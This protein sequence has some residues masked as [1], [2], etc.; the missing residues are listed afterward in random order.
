LQLLLNTF[1]RSKIPSRKSKKLKKLSKAQTVD[2]ADTDTDADAPADINNTNSNTYTIPAPSAMLIETT[3]STNIAQEELC[4]SDSDKEQ[5]CK[6]PAI[7][8][9]NILLINN[10][11]NKL[12]FQYILFG[13]V[14]NFT[15]R[16]YIFRKNYKTSGSTPGAELKD[17]NLAAIQYKLSTI[18]LKFLDKAGNGNR[19]WSE[20]RTWKKDRDFN[21]PNNKML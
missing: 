21:Y 8:L 5:G 10:L 19:F 1:K 9:S 6:K 4:I 12:G 7:Q 18:A 13:I 20:T 16:L 17:W 2:I 14:D 3:T 15:D 11:C